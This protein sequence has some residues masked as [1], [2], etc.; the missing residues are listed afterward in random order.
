MK[1][2]SLRESMQ[3]RGGVAS[4]V[5]LKRADS[6]VSYIIVYSNKRGWRSQLTSQEVQPANITDFTT[7]AG[8]KM[9]Y[10]SKSAHRKDHREN[11]I[12]GWALSCDMTNRRI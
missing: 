12:K 6:G 4:Q 9:E 10:R 7:I 1:L 11:A 3:M 8:V 2:L 5:V